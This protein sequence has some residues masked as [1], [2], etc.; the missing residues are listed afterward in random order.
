MEGLVSTS[1]VAQDLDV[2]EQ[3]PRHRNAELARASDALDLLE[4]CDRFRRVTRQ[5]LCVGEQKQN[6]A[7]FGFVAAHE[8]ER[9]QSPPVVFGCLLVGVDVTSL[10][11]GLKG[12]FQ[13]F[14]CSLVGSSREVMMS[15][16]EG[17]RV[18]GYLLSLQKLG[19]RKMERQATGRRK[20]VV[21]GLADE[22]VGER[23]N[24]G[25]SE[26]LSDDALKK[27][28]LQV[29][30]SARRVASAEFAQ[31]WEIKLATNHGCGRECRDG[32]SRQVPE[33]PSH[34]IGDPLWNSKGLQPGRVESTI[35]CLGGGGSP[36]FA[37]QERI[38]I[39]RL[40]DPT[41]DF[42]RWWLADARAE[43]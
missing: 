13:G 1:R 15:N 21:E 4:G 5:A 9:L 24:P 29:T 8:V 40:E 14:I 11:T 34:D 38:A 10:L 12:P 3:S 42:R 17:G 30:Y 2:A 22:R 27:C 18:V 43:E 37:D 25:R 23:K 31:Q 39:R 28:R 32:G 26:R 6:L 41:N 19:R 36:D 35:L 7:S 20:L 33:M 16:L